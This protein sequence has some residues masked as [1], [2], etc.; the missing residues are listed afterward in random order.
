MNDSPEAKKIRDLRFEAT[1]NAMYHAWR[2]AFLD[3][4][5][6]FFSLV[7]VLAGTA[8]AADL[9]GK[10]HFTDSVQYLAFLAAVAGTFQLVFD[11]GVLAREHDFLQR[12]YYDLVAQIS[13]ETNPS[14]ATVA[15]WER[16]LLRLYADEPAPMRA[17][18]ALAYNAT[19]EAFGV[20]G[21]KRVKVT[22]WQEFLSQ[23]VPFNR[24]EFPYATRESAAPSL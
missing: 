21:S 2:K 7:V 6:R 23:F 8:A 13:E 3:R 22:R 19:I 18:D 11:F 15:K 1:R 5:N 17:L 4:W 10:F 14:E 12:Q 20:P 16:D 24:A 9:G